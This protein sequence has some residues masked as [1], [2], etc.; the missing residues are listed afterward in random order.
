METLTMLSETLT[1]LY[2][3]L[4]TPLKFRI[5]RGQGSGETFWKEDVG[6]EKEERLA[7]GCP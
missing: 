5:E 4:T 1:T 6:S 2:E 3:T 7:V